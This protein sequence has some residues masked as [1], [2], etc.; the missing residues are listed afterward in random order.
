M[1]ARFTC[2]QVF[3]QR[4]RCTFCGTL[5]DGGF[6]VGRVNVVGIV[7][8]CRGSCCFAQVGDITTTSRGGSNDFHGSAFEYLQN[9]AFDA[10]AFGATTKAQKTAND[11]GGSLGRKI[12]AANV[13]RLRRERG[14]SQEALAAQAGIHRNYMG[15][16]ERAE[17]NVAIDNICRLAWALGVDV[18]ELLSPASSSR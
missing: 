15:S 16:V 1:P 13:H 5:F 4:W 14:W 10:T 12:L 6:R 7:G 11:F 18:R 9:R 3:A 17:R 8:V 2:S